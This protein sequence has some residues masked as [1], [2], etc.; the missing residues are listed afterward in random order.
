M[1]QRSPP[2]ENRVRSN[3]G[4]G[5]MGSFAGENPSGTWTLNICDFFNADQGN[6]GVATLYFSSPTDAD[7]SLSVT[8]SDTTPEIGSNVLL[9]YSVTNS[10]GAAATGVTV[11]I[12]LPSGLIFNSQ[13]GT[14]SYNSATGLWT[15][16]ASLANGSVTSITLNAAVQ[17]T[18]SYTIDSEI[19][20]SGQNDPDSTV[21]NG[22]TNEDD[23]VSLTLAP[24]PS[25]IP[26][27]LSCPIA[28]QFTLL[29]G[30][31]GSTN[32]WTAGS[33]NNSYTAGGETI[34]FAVTGDTNRFIART[35]NGSSLQTPVSTTQ[36]ANGAT[37]GEH[38]IVMNVDYA[39]VTESVLTTITLGTAGTGVGQLQFQLLDID[40]GTWVDRITIMGSLNGNPVAPVLTSSGSNTVN[41]PDELIGTAG[42]PTGNPAGNTTV[43]F[44]NAVD[45]V[46]FT[47]DNASPTAN[48]ASQ[49]ISMQ[50]LVMCPS[51]SA[52]ITA[53]KSVAVYDPANL[54]LY[55]TPGNEVEYRI[56]VVN[57]ATASAAADNID[58]SD[59][60]P[61]TVQFVS[62]TTTGF[63]GGAFG[64]PALP[65]ANTDCVGGACVIR[66]SGGTLPINT[67]G[68]IIVRALI[69]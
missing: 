28:D 63:T 19:T 18:G 29:W 22:S 46:T 62:A 25:S 58:I 37:A 16:P 45:T 14:G 10:G 38:G 64:S 27:S 7:L 3:S 33:L 26:P 4:A 12:P 49:V 57:S 17:S 15:L 6:F 5:G 43:T 66:Y 36:F 11:D 1:A 54:G 67:T 35:F 21:N 8:A 32:G 56:T 40:N 20:A 68:E 41:P 55:M 13:T 24:T 2:Y 60:L 51:L 69:K 47:Y 30:A 53:V 50:K 23:D 42:A 34:A 48:P 52:D 61:E 44:Q 65:A 39:A 59:T 31:P 9:T